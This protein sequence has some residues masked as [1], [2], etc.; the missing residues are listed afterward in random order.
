[1]CRSGL[2]LCLAHANLDHVVLGLQAAESCEKL[3]PGPSCDPT[4]FLLPYTPGA[5][6]S[7]LFQSWRAMYLL[8]PKAQFPSPWAPEEPIVFGNAGL[9]WD[10]KP[11]WAVWGWKPFAIVKSQDSQDFAFIFRILLHVFLKQELY[12]RSL[13]FSLCLYRSSFRKRK[14]WDEV[15]EFVFRSCLWILCEDFQMATFSYFPSLYGQPWPT[16][17]GCSSPACP[18]LPQLLS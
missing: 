11:D 9:G 7:S 6:E 18:S 4:P 14:R 13:Y 1:M 16:G 3:Y 17:Q 2:D 5:L 10:A 12:S 15:K 8:I